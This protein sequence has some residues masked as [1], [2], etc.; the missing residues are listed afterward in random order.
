MLNTLLSKF[1]IVRA[2][3]S[4]KL[5]DSGSKIT[6]LFILTA[7]FGSSF[8]ALP[9]WVRNE[10]DVKAMLE[11]ISEHNRIA[12]TLEVIDLSSKTIYYDNG[13]KVLFKRDRNLFGWL[14]PISGPAKPLVFDRSTCQ[15]DWPR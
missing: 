12:A 8:A 11:F 5:C 14:L 2:A 9:P 13:C 7:L 4:M 3:L 10:R 6:I 1:T 15:I